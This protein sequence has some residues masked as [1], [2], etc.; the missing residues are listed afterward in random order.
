VRS[1][2]QD[3]TTKAVKEDDVDR[4]DVYAPRKRG[5]QHASTKS[6]IIIL[7]YLRVEIYIKIYENIKYNSWFK[8]QEL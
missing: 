2:P 4:D 7:N 6:L 3:E 8:V 1:R 5:V